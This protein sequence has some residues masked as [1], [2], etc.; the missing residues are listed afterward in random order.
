MQI[1]SAAILLAFFSALAC[2]RF[3]RYSTAASISPL[4]SVRAFLQSIIPEPV[5]SLNC[6]TCFAVIA[7]ILT[8]LIILYQIQAGHTAVH[9]ALLRCLGAAVR[10]LSD[11]RVPSAACS[12]SLAADSAARASCWLASMFSSPCFASMTASAILPQIS[13]TARIASSLPGMT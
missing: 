10:R 9:P 6:L 4:V 5:I 13:L 1:P 8:S 11:Y 3:L 12:A 2:P 7:I